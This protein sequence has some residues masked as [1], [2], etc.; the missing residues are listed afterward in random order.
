MHMARGPQR[1]KWGTE[2]VVEREGSPQSEGKSLDTAEV[3]STQPGAPRTPVSSQGLLLSDSRSPFSTPGSGGIHNEPHI[4]RLAHSLLDSQT[5]GSSTA[6]GSELSEYDSELYLQLGPPSSPPGHP[7]QRR[8]S[9]QHPLQVEEEEEEALEQGWEEA[10][11]ALGEALACSLYSA[12]LMES[13]GD[14]GEWEGSHWS[15]LPAGSSLD[16]SSPDPPL[17]P[18]SSPSLS[19]NSGFP[20]P[21]PLCSSLSQRILLLPHPPSE[22]P[23][24]EKEVEVGKGGEARDEPRLTTSNRSGSRRPRLTSEVSGRITSLSVAD[25]DFLKQE[26][27]WLPDEDERLSRASRPDHLDFLRITPPEYDIIST[28]LDLTRVLRLR[29]SL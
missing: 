7:G 4:S 19:G 6:L 1:R 28:S 26:G 10:L 11:P 27:V 15:P 14:Y 13:L 22:E 2:G 8:A 3:T 23:E 21:T 12:L 5:C 18:P 16:R 20:R 29:H 24:E 25:G 17:P 9:P